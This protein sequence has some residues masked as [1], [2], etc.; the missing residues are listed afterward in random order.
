MRTQ[1]KTF[2]IIITFIFIFISLTACF[3]FDKQ[4]VKVGALPLFFIE[5]DG[6]QNIDSKEKYISCQISVS[7]T[8]NA[9]YSFEASKA[10][11][12]GRGNSTW[13]MPKK[14]Y[15]IKFEQKLDLF[16]NGEAKE[17]TLIANYADP[18]LIRNYLAYSIGAKMEHLMYTTTVQFVDLYTNGSYEGVYLVC[19]QIETGENRVN[20]EENLDEVDTGYLIE[21]DARAVEEGQKDIDYF[22]IGN[23]NYTVKYPQTDEEDWTLAHMDFI[24][25]YTSEAFR[26]LSLGHYQTVC[27]YIDVNTFADAYIIH[28]LFNS[29]DVGYSSF[30][31]YKDKAD[32]LCAGPLWDF[33]VSVGNCNYHIQEGEK[34]FKW[35]TWAREGNEW[36]RLLFTYEEFDLLVTQKLESYKEKIIT[37]IN[38]KTDYVLSCKDTFERNFQRWEILGSYVWPNTQVLVDIDSWEGHVDYVKTWLMGALESLCEIYS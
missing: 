2:T 18:S 29:I 8:K 6:E 30:F 23:T 33:D 16:G 34:E 28:E 7:N 32:R 38:E 35:R 3:P 13:G 14:P 9:K 1:K 27:Q 17:W 24:K 21:L 20:I 22:K 10:K 12:K 31:M 5:T 11:I 26:A 4:E 25:N 36:Y 15:K 19:E 37:V